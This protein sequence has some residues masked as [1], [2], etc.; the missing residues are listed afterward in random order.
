LYDLYF[1]ENESRYKGSALEYCQ[2]LFHWSSRS[3]PIRELEL[4]MDKFIAFLNSNMKEEKDKLTILG[5]SDLHACAMYNKGFANKQTGNYDKAIVL[6]KQAIKIIKTILKV[7][8][9]YPTMKSL[10][11]F[12]KALEKLNDKITE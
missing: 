1:G 4:E 9:D 8:S 6:Y 11:Y 10:G 3:V 12:E 2:A 7:Q 5:I